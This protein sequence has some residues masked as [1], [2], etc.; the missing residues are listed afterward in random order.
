MRKEFIYKAYEKGEITAEEKVE[1]VKY[2]CDLLKKMYAFEDEKQNH[3]EL[4]K[5]RK[6][7]NAYTTNELT[8]DFY[9]KAKYE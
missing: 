8:K 3:D 2:S 5:F 7:F 9:H 1:Y 6:V 4:E